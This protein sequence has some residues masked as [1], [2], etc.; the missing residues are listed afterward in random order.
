MKLKN[1][2]RVLRRDEQEAQIGS[3]P[4]V[5]V[6]LRLEHPSEF[7]V[8]Q[9]LERDQTPGNL[10]SELERLG[11]DRERVDHLLHKLAAAGLL[12][13]S[14]RNRSAELQVDP[15]RRDILAPEAETRSLA[16]GNGWRQMARRGD[17]CVSV[18]GLGRTGAHIALGLAAAGVGKLQLHDPDPV[19]PRDRGQLFG[20]QHLGLERAAAVAQIIAGQS[21]N[22]QIC[23]SG[24][25]S[26][27]QAAVLVDYEVADPNRSAFLSAH[28]IA[29][30]SVVVG[31]LSISCGPWVPNAAGPCLR[32]VRLWAVE[33]DPCWPGLATQRFARSA[34]AARGEDSSLAATAGAVAVGE[35]LQGLGGVRPFTAGRALVLR[36]PSYAIHWHDVDVHPKCG[37]HS[38]QPRRSRK[39]SPPPPAIA[40]PPAL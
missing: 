8:L 13:I 27:P 35:V 34:V 28:G 18:Y 32:C 31:E 20:P 23:T 7:N 40:L 5:A 11:G 12:Q 14:S 17:Q 3:D 1:G 6:T 19:T 29:H 2:L 4:V 24:R 9:L 36:Q 37:D 16:G 39:L 38:P 25:W 22:C 15:Q 30:L 26:R 10:R 33:K 21:L